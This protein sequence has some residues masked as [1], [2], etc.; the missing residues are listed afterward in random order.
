ML[1]LFK[2]VLWDKHDTAAAILVLI[3]FYFIQLLFILFSA[4]ARYEINIC[5][6]ATEHAQQ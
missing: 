4:C 5:T 1:F 2:H 6:Q 3:V